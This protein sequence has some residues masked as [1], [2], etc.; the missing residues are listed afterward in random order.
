M[1]RTKYTI[2]RKYFEIFWKKKMLNQ[3]LHELYQYVVYI[4]QILTM[5][6]TAHAY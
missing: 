2:K 4:L 1:K 5:E 3:C 6:I